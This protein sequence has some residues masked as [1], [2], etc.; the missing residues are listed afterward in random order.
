MAS[1]RSISQQSP[2]PKSSPSQTRPTVARSDDYPRICI[3][4]NAAAQKQAKDSPNYEYIL[5]LLDEAE[6][7]TSSGAR[8]LTLYWPATSDELDALVA[9]AQHCDPTYTPADL[10]AW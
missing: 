7:G 5:N 9:R 6:A 3:K 10:S 1:S 8:V 2:L 4:F